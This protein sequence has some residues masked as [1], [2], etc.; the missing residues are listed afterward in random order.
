MFRSKCPNNTR[1]A[2][3]RQSYKKTIRSNCEE[4]RAAMPLLDN[5]FRTS[6]PRSL[7]T[8]VSTAKWGLVLIIAKIIII[9][10]K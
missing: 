3:C 2:N 9:K 8:A 1:Q 7:Q 6:T 10:P 5:S 4:T